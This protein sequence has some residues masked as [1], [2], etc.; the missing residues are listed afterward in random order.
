[1][2]W[3]IVLVLFQEDAS[4]RLQELEER[5]KK[6]EEQR[7]IQ[8]KVPG[9]ESLA[10]GGQIRLRAEFR[11]VADYRVP[12]TFGRAAGDHAED[13]STFAV[14]RMR[15]H[16]DAAVS[17]KLRVFVQL[18]D[19]RILGDD[20]IGGDTADFDMKQGFLEVREIADVPLSIKAGRMEVPTLGDG[21]LISPLDWSNNGRSWD[22][23]QVTFAPEG[24]SILA[25]GVNLAEGSLFGARS[26]NDHYMVGAYATCRKLE[27]HEFDFYLLGRLLADDDFASESGGPLGPRKDGT[28][29]IR[30]KGKA[31]FADYS[32]E[33]VFQFGDQ[34]GDDVR[35]WAVVATAGVTFDHDWK[36]RVGFEYAFASGDGDPSDGNLRTFDPIFPFGHLYHGHADLV[37]WRNVHAF[38]MALRAQPAKEVSV[39]LD[40]HA[41]RLAEEEDAWLSAAGTAIR[42]DP[43]G[44]AD[45][46]VGYEIDLYARWKLLERLEFWAGYS[47]FFAGGYVADTGDDADQD[48]VF[49]QVALNF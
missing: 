32:G 14:E 11:D 46:W 4:R 21:R 15:L 38:M 44:A 41:F 13:Y 35:A 45:P 27:N 28:V 24:W 19:S 9:L 3:L 2:S 29:G 22:G 7:G 31:W 48:W 47:H 26:K 37:G 12:G 20:P 33:L 42:R 43:T 8:L 40:V 16:L 25:W 5:V 34:N 49:F 30:G 36:P 17:R 39:H 10:I 1:M 23:V 18:Q 6:L